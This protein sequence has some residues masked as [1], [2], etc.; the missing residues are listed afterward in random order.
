MADSSLIPLSRINWKNI[1]FFLS[2]L[3]ILINLSDI[4]CKTCKE[5][6]ALSETDCFNNIIEIN[7]LVNLIGCNKEQSVILYAI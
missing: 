5:S 7:I 1:L 4:N 6:T 3:I 2:F